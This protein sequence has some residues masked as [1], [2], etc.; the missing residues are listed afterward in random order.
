MGLLTSD[1]TQEVSDPIM[2]SCS[3]YNFCPKLPNAVIPNP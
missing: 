2:A 3:I 1:C